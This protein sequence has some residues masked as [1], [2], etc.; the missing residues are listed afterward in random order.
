MKKEIDL[1]IPSDNV[2][3]HVRFISAVSSKSANGQQNGF[4]RSHL[5]NGSMIYFPRFRRVNV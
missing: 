5:S 2:N 1:L 3:Y 4:P